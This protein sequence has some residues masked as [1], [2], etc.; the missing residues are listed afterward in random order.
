MPST[1]M[2]I[3]VPPL[4]H[5]IVDSVGVNTNTE[6]VPQNSSR[7]KAKR[8]NGLLDHVCF[9]LVSSTSPILLNNVIRIP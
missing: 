6:F 1:C 2:R 4:M 3:G 9:D 5:R 8:I 7:A